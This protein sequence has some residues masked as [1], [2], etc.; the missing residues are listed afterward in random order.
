MGVIDDYVLKLKFRKSF[1]ARIYPSLSKYYVSFDL[2]NSMGETI[3]SDEIILRRGDAYT[4]N[5]KKYEFKY[6]NQ[7][8]EAYELVNF[9]L[10]LKDCSYG[11]SIVK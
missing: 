10:I 6:F 11:N 3:E 1:P 8:N 4:G 2:V 7:S 5:Y 9:K